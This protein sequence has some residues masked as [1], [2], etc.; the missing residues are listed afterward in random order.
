M[1][2]LYSALSHFLRTLN[3]ACLILEI[4]ECTHQ[5]IELRMFGLKRKILQG[6][7]IHDFWNL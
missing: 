1:V 4:M 7:V 2:P 5:Q 6:H 3:F